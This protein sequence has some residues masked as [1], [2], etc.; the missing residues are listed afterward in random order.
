MRVVW[1]GFALLGLASCDAEQ[2]GPDSV[3]GSREAVPFLIDWDPEPTYLGIYY[4]KAA[5]LFERAGYDVDIVSL[6]G[7]N[8]V[9]QA[10]A[11]GANPIGT[12]SGGATV[13]GAAN[14]NRVLSM[15]VLYPQISTVVYGYARTGIREPQDLIG[16]RIAIYPTSIT[17]NEFEAFRRAQNIP[18][19]RIQV[20]DAV[21]SDL[22]FLAQNQA[23]AVL[24]YAE[25]SP[26]RLATNP[27]VAP[28]DG[29]R[30]FELYL[31]NYGVS[32]YGLN[33][34][35][36]PAAYKAD[37]KKV[38]ALSNAA[39]EG[40]V[41]GCRN[42]PAAVEAFLRPVYR[43]KDRMERERAYVTLSWDRICDRLMGPK[44]GEQTAKGWV[45]TIETYSRLGL[46][47]KPVTPQDVLP[48]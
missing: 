40:Y 37:P 20:V 39:L 8:A 14:G 13:I 24:N 46:L 31:S 6:R 3:Q 11:S 38:R 16:K 30:S 23:D 35:A 36:S 26:S 33:I 27:K 32:G 43:S 22:E 12:A 34:I 2:G 19:D 45:T 15:A 4:A 18:A 10:V 42:R 41:R 25:M 1:L 9:V 47:P 7:A 21:G 44:P 28:V 17:K 29:K 5:G 48:N